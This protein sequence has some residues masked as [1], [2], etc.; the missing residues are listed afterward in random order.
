MSDFIG[1]IIVCVIIFILCSICG[2]C[3]RRKHQGAIYSTPVVV[4]SQTHTTSGGYPITTTVQ[5]TASGGFQ[6]TPYPTTM[7]MPQPVGNFSNPPYPTG[8]G[9]QPMP[10]PMSQ[11]SP[12]PPAPGFQT[13][14]TPYPPAAQSVPSA[15]SQNPPSYDQVVGTDTYTKQA[16]YNPNYVNN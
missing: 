12:Y 1:P 3:C 7:P 14:A 5:S 4:T 15:A 6:A 11:T 8:F 2:Y 10:Q 16:P 13:N 9:A